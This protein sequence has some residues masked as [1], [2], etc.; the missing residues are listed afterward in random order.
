MSSM[1]LQFDSTKVIE[2]FRGREMAS[3]L[4]QGDLM[5]FTEKCFNDNPKDV[6][7]LDSWCRYFRSVESCFAVTKHHMFTE[8][9]SGK[10]GKQRIF[11]ILWKERRDHFSIGQ[12]KRGNMG[13]QF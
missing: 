9:K 6:Q 8:L 4:K 1:E 11:S 2:V 7:I 10:P 3:V 13:C 5:Q 12:Y